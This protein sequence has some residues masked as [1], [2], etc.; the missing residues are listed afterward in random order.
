MKLFPIQS[1][2]S[3]VNVVPPARLLALL[4]QSLKWQQHQGLLPPGERLF[5]LR[6]RARSAGLRKGERRYLLVGDCLG[7]IMHV[8]TAGLGKSTGF[9]I[10]KQEK[11]RGMNGDQSINWSS[12]LCVSWT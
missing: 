8:R 1:L 4:A 3:E 2:S 9:G 5:G 10:I 12:Q 11:A 6:V 7:L